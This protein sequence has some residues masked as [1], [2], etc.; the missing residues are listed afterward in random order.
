MKKKRFSK[1]RDWINVIG[2]LYEK[3]LEQSVLDKKMDEE[4]TKNL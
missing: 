4:K 3:T 2:L 1:L